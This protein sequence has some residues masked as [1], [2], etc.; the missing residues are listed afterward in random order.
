MVL[1]AGAIRGPARVWD[2]LGAVAGLLLPITLFA[3]VLRAGSRTPDYD[4][5]RDTISEL[6]A[7]GAY[8]G[9]FTALNVAS[10]ALVLAFAFAV[11]R[12]L[13]VGLSTAVILGLV[14][15]GSMLIGVVPCAIVSDSTNGHCG[16]V[17]AH[18]SVALLTVVL[19]VAFQV[20]AA[21]L[22]PPTERWR[23]LRRTSWL[24]ASASSL[25][26]S[27][28]LVSSMLDGSITGL[29]ERLFWA[30]G[31]VWVV[32]GSVQVLLATKAPA[33]RQFS[34]EKLQQKTVR[35][36]NAQH[37][38]YLTYEISD[39]RQAKLWIADA[40]HKEVVCGDA[41]VPTPGP[42]PASVTLA[43]TYQGLLKLGVPYKPAAEADCFTEGMRARSHLL[44]D[45]GESETCNWDEPWRSRDIHLLAWV[46]APDEKALND[47]IAGLRGLDGFAGLVDEHVQKARQLLDDSNQPVEN[48]GFRDGYSQ[49]WVA[50]VDV[51][52]SPGLGRGKLDEWGSWR[53]IALGEFVLGEPDESNDT[54]PLPRPESVYHHG[55]FLV[56]RKLAQNV[57]RWKEFIGREEESRGLATGTLGPMIFGRHTDGRPVW[58]EDTKYTGYNNFTFD[59]DPEGFL[60]P[61][62]SH[63]RRANP[64]S[65]GSFIGALTSRRR[66]LRRGMTY[67]ENRAADDEWSQ[68]IMFVA[69]VAR[70]GDQFEFV[71]RMWLN[72]G[73]RQG[74]GTDRDVIGGGGDG[75]TRMVLQRPNQPIVIRDIP[76]F[77]KTLGGEYF[78][79]PSMAGLCAIVQSNTDQPIDLLPREIQGS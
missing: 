17:G 13:P 2:F 78:F 32:A 28:L 59:N 60:C 6:G 57:A 19:I 18:A 50:G 44:G 10:F 70:L 51:N 67:V 76:Q 20:A 48:F 54:P 47:A 43:F 45:L 72:D 79:V 42:A 39:P 66:M 55:S 75:T 22:V 15:L 69:V 33:V 63:I 49:P 41:D 4:Q 35:V 11:Y 62:G 26:A 46:H 1:R 16:L 21:K 3:F 53:P 37:G 12:R 58:L 31:Y 30:V 65:A 61:L 56:V 23:G 24:T 7:T 5:V 68:G 77:V 8:T 38:A 9:W 73:D 74:Q 34:F 25:L 27:A 40:M 71:Q 52:K 64:R 36:R 29:L 14:G